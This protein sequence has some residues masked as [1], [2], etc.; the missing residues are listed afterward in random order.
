MPG[1]AEGAFLGGGA[2]LLV[3]FL[4][5]ACAG[6]QRAERAPAE[7]VSLWRLGW[8]GASRD[9]L[10]SLLTAGLIACASFII[11]VVAANRKDLSRANT[12]E[13]R[14]GAGGFSLLARSDVPI[15]ADLNTAAGRE[16]LGLPPEAA[17][18]IRPDEVLFVPHDR[19]R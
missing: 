19:R 16:A 18:G 15:M 6:F 5:L 7:R 14:S 11:V 13:R 2:L 1:A 8:R 12:A 17:G 3:G 9:W 4:A 10:R